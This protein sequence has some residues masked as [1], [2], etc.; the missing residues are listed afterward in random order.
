MTQNSHTPCPLAE[1]QCIPCKGGIGPLKPSEIEP[2]KAQLH[3][4]WHIVDGRHLERKF[5]F[6]DFKAAL[7]FANKVGAIAEE[8]QHHPDIQVGWGKVVV[9]LCT[10]KIKGLHEN[11]FILAAKVDQL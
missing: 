3:P 5:K 7:E 11:D 1:N 2:L 8:Q 10:H 9:T 6:K 4:D